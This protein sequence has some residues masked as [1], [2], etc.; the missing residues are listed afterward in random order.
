MRRRFIRDP[1]NA[2]IPDRKNTNK[3][4]KEKRRES[5]SSVLPISLLVLVTTMFMNSP[6][7]FSIFP[8]LLLVTTLL[9][10]A[11]NVSSTRLILLNGDMGVEAAGGVIRAFVQAQTDSMAGCSQIPH[12]R[13]IVQDLLLGQEE[14]TMQM[15]F[16]KRPHAL[17]HRCGVGKG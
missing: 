16:L 3:K 9:R 10:L 15:I 11:L 8:S 12:K 7:E 13:R 2:L 17:T 5:L 1:L 6:L 4:L 14:S